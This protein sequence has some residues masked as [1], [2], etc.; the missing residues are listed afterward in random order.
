MKLKLIKFFLKFAI[1]IKYYK[2]WSKLYNFLFMRKYKNIKIE[3]KS[4]LKEIES[5]LFKLSY[6]KDGWKE[7]W[8]VCAS[9]QYVQHCLNE[10]KAGRKQ[11]S[12][13]LDCD[14][15]SRYCRNIVPNKYLPHLLS[16]IYQRLD[17]SIGGHM[18]C[19]VSDLDDTNK[20]E[21]FHISNWGLYG[22]YSSTKDVIQSILKDN[23][24][25]GACIYSKELDPLV[26]ENLCN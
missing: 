16:V 6:R 3:K 21:M 15:F 20:L 14:E 4:S 19:V 7:L 22:P 13:P 18:V 17:K 11:P 24:L 23:T 2:R 25:I 12:G 1:K 26:W 9:P 8:D 10:V 5:D